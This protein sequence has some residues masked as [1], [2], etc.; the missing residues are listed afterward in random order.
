M[1]SYKLEEITRSIID[2]GGEAYIVDLNH[3]VKEVDY[4]GK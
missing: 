2:K 3:E 1:N 4:A